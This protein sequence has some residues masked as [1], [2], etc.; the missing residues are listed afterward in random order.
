MLIHGAKLAKQGSIACV[1]S[2]FVFVAVCVVV[3]IQYS[4]IDYY[5]VC[6]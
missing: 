6:G 1:Y 5:S 3:Y 2:L 4:Y